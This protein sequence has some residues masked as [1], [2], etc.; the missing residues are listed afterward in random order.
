MWTRHVRLFPYS[1]RPTSFDQQSTFTVS[2]QQAAF[3]KSSN[4]AREKEETSAAMPQQPSR[5][6]TSDSLIELPLHDEEMLLPENHTKECGQDSTYRTLPLCG[7]QLEQTTFDKLESR[8]PE[9]ILEGLQL[10]SPEVSRVQSPE[11]TPEA[12]LSSIIVEVKQVSQEACDQPTENTPVAELKQVSQEVSEEPTENI[13]VVEVKLASQEVSE[14]ARENIPEAKV[15]SVDLGFQV[16]EGNEAVE[17]SQ[18]D[19]M[20]SNVHRE[21]DYKSE[22]DLKPLSL[23]SLS[24]NSQENTNLD[25]IPSTSPKCEASPETCTSNGKKIEGNCNSNQDSYMHSPSNTRS[26]ES[27]GNEVVNAMPIP[28]FSQ[29]PVNSYGDWRQSNHSDKVC[30]DSKFG[31]RGQLQRKSHQQEHV[32]PQ[33]YPR[34]AGCPMPVSQG[35]PSVFAPSH[36]QQI[37]QGSRPAQHHNQYQVASGHANIPAANAGPMPNLQAGNDASS[38]QSSLPVQPVTPQMSQ[39]SVLG[40]GQ[41]AMPN[42][43]A[44]NQMWQ[45]Y[46]YQQQQQHQPQQQQQLF[47]QQHH[48]QQQL[49]QYY[50]QMQQQQ[51]LLQQQQ[52]FQPLQ[53]QLPLQQQQQS[54]VL[55]QLP[56]QEQQQFQQ[57]QQQL[58]QF[59][60]QQQQYQQ[61]QKQLPLQQQPQFQQLQQQLPLQQQQY[62]Q[63][64]QL[65]QQ[66]QEQQHP[67]YVQKHQQPLP[68]QSHLQEQQKISQSSIQHN[69]SHHQV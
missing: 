46:Y 2:D 28:V 44:Y 36:N 48:Q 25:L 66:Q 29:P 39:S 17:S 5:V 55:K 69:Y 52:Q 68:Q 49:Q 67:F 64:L 61:L 60:Q 31:F 14:E 35:H 22:Q 57:L 41:Y 6:C 51:L 40:N 56:L 45:Y 34:T 21:C 27:A 3:T 18:E 33:K 62:N 53:Q 58:H 63:Q 11:N 15:S 4:L 10:P 42:S 30:K 59:Q 13:P 54:Q 24:L 65:Q 16:A 23:E 47:L 7:S 38:S 32:P 26:L 50:V 9:T 19:T 20:G 1:I 43:Q 8:L 37:Q 12:N